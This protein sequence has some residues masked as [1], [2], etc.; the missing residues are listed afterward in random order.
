[1]KN[2]K[3]RYAML[4]FPAVTRLCQSFLEVDFTRR[5]KEIQVPTCIMVG[6]LDLIKGPA[7]AK[8]LKKAI[9]HAEYHQLAG[10]GHA[11]CW[12]RPEEFNSV[13]LGFLAKQP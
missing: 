7:Y 11:T 12:E 1:M 8:I 2:E 3:K 4:D 6:E 5:L 10:S 13:I 9:P